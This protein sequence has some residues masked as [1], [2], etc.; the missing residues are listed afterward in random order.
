MNIKGQ[1][2]PKICGF[3]SILIT[4]CLAMSSFR[5]VSLNLNG[6]RDIKK[7]AMCF[8]LLKTKCVDIAFVQ[9]MH[10]NHDNEVEGKREWD[11]NIVLT[12]KSTASAGV[13][14][15]FSKSFLTKSFDLEEV[16]KG[17]LIKVVARYEK[18]TVILLNVQ[19]MV[20]GYSW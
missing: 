7:R 19:Y 9:E 5:I 8:D 18:S 3:F 4:L 13:E 16:V 12:H 11:G 15:L 14:I 2:Q 10:S 20:I 6:E 17:R 1:E